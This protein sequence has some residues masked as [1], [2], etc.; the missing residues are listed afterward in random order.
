MLFG[1]QDTA[2]WLELQFNS[3][4]RTLVL[5]ALPLIGKTSFLKHAG[6]LQ[7]INA[8]HLVISLSNLSPAEAARSKAN[9]PKL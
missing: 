6:V 5:S 7:N 4:N 1:R 3:G 8:V 2:D 9:K